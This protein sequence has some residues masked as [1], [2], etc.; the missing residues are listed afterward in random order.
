MSGRSEPGTFHQHILGSSRTVRW[1]NHRYHGQNSHVLLSYHLLQVDRL[2]MGIRSNC[3]Q[4]HGIHRHICSRSCTQHP[5]QSRILRWRP[6]TYR[7]ECSRVPFSLNFGKYHGQSI[8]LGKWNG[9]ILLPRNRRNMHIHHFYDRK[10]LY[11]SIQPVACGHCLAE[12]MQPTH[13][14]MGT[15]EES[16][17]HQSMQLQKPNLYSQQR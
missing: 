8:R 14:Q 13:T 17:Q 16:N 5:K 10:Y 9:G 1:C 7:M 15:C 3:S 4:V 12:E 6:A 2:L 11:P